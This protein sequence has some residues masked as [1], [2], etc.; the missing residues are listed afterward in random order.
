MFLHF[1]CF[2]LG[3]G[4]MLQHEDIAIGGIKYLRENIGDSL[5][6]RLRDLK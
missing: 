5:S 3:G 4:G 1:W 2:F 6:S